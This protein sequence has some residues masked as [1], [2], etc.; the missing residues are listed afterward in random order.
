MKDWKKVIGQNKFQFFFFVTMLALLVVALVITTSGGPRDDGL[1]D[2]SNQPSDDNDNNNNNNP[3]DV[4]DIV[5]EVFVLP[6]NEKEYTV[7]RKFYEKDGTKEDQ[8][9]SLIKYNNSYRTS[10]GTGYAMKD[11]SSFNVVATMSGK[12]IEVKDSPLFGKC[13]IIEHDDNIKTYYYGLSDV[14]VT[15]GTVVNQG[16]K[17][18]VSGYTELDK[19]AGNYV[20]FQVMKKNTYL[21]PE[22]I[23]GKKTSEL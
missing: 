10:Q 16:D 7:V 2:D 3:S 9:K 1:I 19:E 11:N 12:I 17:I 5:D 21:N 15:K 13:V 4:V 14:N 8:A 18:G 6:F 20:Y 23:L 22:K